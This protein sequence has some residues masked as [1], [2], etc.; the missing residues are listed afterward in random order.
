[1]PVRL[2]TPPVV[3]PV[4]VAEAKTHLRLEETADDAYVNGLITTARQWAE[5]VCWRGF[6]SQVYELVLPGFRGED[7]HELAERGPV[8][9]YPTAGEW[10]GGTQVAYRFLPYLELHWGNLDP[11]TPIVAFTY[12]DPEGATQTLS[13]SVYSVDYITVPGRVR[14]AF[15]QSWPLT[16]E[17]WN[18]VTIQYKVGWAAAN[19][20]SPIK[21][22]IMLQLSAMY[23]ERSP[24]PIDGISTLDAL[25]SPYRLI[26]I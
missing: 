22:A 12:V 5:K 3:E 19:V 9:A 10:I 18:A 15:G 1:M 26:R 23:E 21:H 7:R 17:Q 6:V 2:L 20:P 14:L 4:T 24:E 16:R 11:V 13:S 8:S 25:L